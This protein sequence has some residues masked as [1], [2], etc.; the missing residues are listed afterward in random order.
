MQVILVQPH[1]D[2]CSQLWSPADQEHINRI[3]TVQRSLIS[4]VRTSGLQGL[5]YWQKLQSLRL[6]SQE[7]RRERY[8]MI[9]IWKVSQGLV[10][11]YNLQFT[12][13]SS[14]TGRKVIP[15]QVLLSASPAV[16]NAR[17]ASLAV[18]GAQLLNFLPIQLRNSEHGDILMFK[19]MA[20]IP[21]EPT[22]A[23]LVRR[24]QTNS[25]LHQILMFENSF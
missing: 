2:Y 8:T 25:L 18:K 4:K 10:S 6:Y 7:R 9:F 5:S 17:A 13:R 24:A 3:E 20:D 19:N 1:L 15:A 21:D 23:G 22:V 16:R 14:R 11:G 12:S